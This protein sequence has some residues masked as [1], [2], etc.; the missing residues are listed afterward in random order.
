[1]MRKEGD[2][3]YWNYPGNTAIELGEYKYYNYEIFKDLKENYVGYFYYSQ[4]K[5]KKVEV[6]AF[7]RLNLPADFNLEKYVNTILANYDASHRS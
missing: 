1:L 2:I 6:N 7:N 4:K 3:Y 5:R